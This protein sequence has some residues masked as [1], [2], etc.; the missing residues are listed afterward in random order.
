MK[1]LHYNYFFH[2]MSCETLFPNNYF[3]Y[4]LTFHPLIRNEAS[5]P[6]TSYPLPEIKTGAHDTAFPV[7]LNPFQFLLSLHRLPTTLTSV[8]QI[9]FPSSDRCLCRQC[10]SHCFETWSSLAAASLGWCRNN[11]SVPV[12]YDFAFR[13]VSKKSAQI[14]TL[15]SWFWIVY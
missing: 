3:K 10:S 8:V 14:F 9:H 11:V 6:T 15:P 4:W 5:M 2:Q 13:K 12:V 7:T 1:H